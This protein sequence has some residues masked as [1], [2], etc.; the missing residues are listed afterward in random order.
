MAARIENYGLIG[1]SQ[2]TALISNE[3]SLDWLCAP[4][5]DFDACFAALVG[6]DE[7]G[8]W[9]LRPTVAVR[10]RKQRYRG[11]TL[12]LETEVECDGGVVRHTDFMP[13]S[14]SRCDV[15][16]VVEGVEGEV[17]MEM[18]LNVRFGYGTS[19]PWVTPTANGFSGVSG[20]DA[21]LIRS[22]VKMEQ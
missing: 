19:A 3:G 4:R 17:P 6:Y 11:D 5:F 14:D 10:Q 12:V 1:N 2:T 7:H 18:L 13:Q 21:A 16:R 15:I 9:A 22:S 8:R 20:P